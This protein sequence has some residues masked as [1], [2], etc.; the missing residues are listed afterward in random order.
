MGYRSVEKHAE[1]QT[2][3]QTNTNTSRRLSRTAV[4]KCASAWDVNDGH[5][6]KWLPQASCIKLLKGN[7]LLERFTIYTRR[8]VI[9]ISVRLSNEGLGEGEMSQTAN[10][11]ISHAVYTEEF[12]VRRCLLLYNA[13]HSYTTVKNVWSSESATKKWLFIQPVVI[14]FGASL[15]FWCKDRQRQWTI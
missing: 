8:T 11:R 14:F 13:D 4:A 10:K 9:W 3:K 7:V 5:V 12:Q 1:K 15:I 6:S 2:N